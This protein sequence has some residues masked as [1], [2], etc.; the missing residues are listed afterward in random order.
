MLN[1]ARVCVRMPSHGQVW[2]FIEPTT[3]VQEFKVLCKAEDSAIDE[4]DITDGKGLIN[5]SD[6]LYKHLHSRVPLNLRI[7]NIQYS[8][9][10]AETT[11]STPT[12]TATDR[13]YN[14]LKKAGLS[15]CASNTLSLMKR[16]L[17]KDL[18]DSTPIKTEELQQ[19][20]IDEVRLFESA[21]IREQ[22]FNLYT[23]KL[24]VQTEIALLDKKL[25]EIKKIDNA[26][27]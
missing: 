21:V 27:S 25:S 18:S 7:N 8:F 4:I 12:E 15:Y 13:E 24:N 2:F 23:I 11:P 5:N 19:K 10:T 22:I 6:S 9:D 20:F 17:L 14:K 3:T 26:K 1:S 16:N